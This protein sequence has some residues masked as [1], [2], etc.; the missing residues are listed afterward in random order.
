MT[1]Q[2][3]YENEGHKPKTEKTNKK[4]MENNDKHT[5]EEYEQ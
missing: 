2:S 1:D 5:G 4:R 3:D